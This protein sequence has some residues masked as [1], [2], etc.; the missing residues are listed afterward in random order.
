MFIVDTYCGYH[1]HNPQFDFINRPYGSGDYLFVLFLE[2]MYVYLGTDKILTKPNACLLFPPG[3]PQHYGHV[4]SFFNSFVHF[5]IDS[6]FFSTFKIPENQILYPR[7]HDLLDHYMKLIEEQFYSKEALYEDEIHALLLQLFIKL[8]RD[9][10]TSP[11]KLPTSKNSHVTTND[12]NALKTARLK[13]LATSYQPWT[14][15]SMAALAH[16]SVSQFYY[17][18]KR[19]FDTSPKADLLQ[20]RLNF[21]KMLMLNSDYTITQAAQLSGF[22]DIP[23]FSR[24]FKKQFGFSPRAYIQLHQSQ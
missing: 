3:A 11:I 24:Y 8:H 18:Y 22:E 5:K 17:H 12:Y 4:P 14:A 9:L 1:V 2:P 7:S 15:Q 6:S 16:M 19:Y 21:A 23:H 13:I 10:H 20:A